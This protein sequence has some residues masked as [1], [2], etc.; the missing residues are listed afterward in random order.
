M[1]E[2]HAVVMVKAVFSV[3]NS[4]IDPRLSTGKTSENDVES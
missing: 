1:N 3:L 4:V 2:K